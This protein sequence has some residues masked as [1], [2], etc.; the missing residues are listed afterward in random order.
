MPAS[1]YGILFLLIPFKQPLAASMPSPVDSIKIAFAN[2][3]SLKNF[4]KVN[5]IIIRGNKLTRTTI[6]LREL[7]LKEGDVVTPADLH[8]ILEKDARKLFNLHLFNTA[9]VKPVYLENGMI[10]ILVEVTERWYTFPVPR[11]QLSDRNFNE[12]WQNY[13]HDF[14]RVN[15]GIKLY[16]YNLW[17]RNH[18]LFIKAQFGFQK[19]FQFL[20]RIPYI[21][22]K[23]KQGLV[24]EFD[25]IEGKN[26]ADSTI[27]HRLNFI[28]SRSTLRVT[29]GAGITYTYR[30]N[31]YEQHRLK[32]EYRQTS[33]AD[34]L[35]VLNPNYLGE[36]RT[37]QRF[38][39]LTYEFV[40]DHRD[41]MAYPLK[42]YELYF[43]IQKSGIGLTKDLRKTAGFLSF[44][45]FLD[46]HKKFYFSNLSFVYLSSP[47]GIPY[48]NYGGLG[49][50][51][52]FVKG[53]ET[54]VIEG[55]RFFLN[56]TTLKKRIF[57]RHWNLNNKFIPQFNYL[58][59]S[60]YF[61]AYTDLGY[62]NNYSAY[63]LHS[64]NNYLSDRL[65]AGA[66]FGLDFVCAY[67]LV[68]RLE[69]TFT[70]QN[71]GGLFLH[72]KKEF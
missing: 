32:Y 20:Y 12:W 14:S 25:L 31:F 11:F 17:G 64:V 36:A 44:A 59:L 28:E 13:Y 58:P 9:T 71:Q 34:T 65:L 50:D 39:A 15:Y 21:N 70:A 61:K 2:T 7:Q 41:V 19:H 37:R 68:L 16:Q 72:F 33:I 8:G 49:Y 26:V 30:Q 43:H 10:D 27:E 52:I 51:K 46:L 63:T 38:D 6:I 45:G 4:L 18:T 42:G 40:S 62:V 5:S 35:R 60:I 23:Q 48:F 55:P 47:N 56:K 69:Y 29:Q 54:Y 57:S 22:R 24:F 66:G 1:I 67:D 53:Y 3:D